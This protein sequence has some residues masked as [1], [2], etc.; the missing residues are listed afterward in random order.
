MTASS[1]IL[2][3]LF[4]DIEGSTLLWEQDPEAMR[5]ALT[6]HDAVLHEIIDEHGGRLF[7]HTGD[8][9]C[10]AFHSP[11]AA[12]RAAI[13]AQ[14]RSPLPVRIGLATGEAEPRADDYFGPVLNRTARVMSAGHGGQ[15]LLD[16]ATAGLLTSV[17]LVGLGP[18]RLRG[19]LDPVTLYQVRA[20]GLETD[21]P[22]LRT[23]DSTPGNLRSPTS[24]FVG[25][26]AELAGLAAAIGRHRL[27]TLTG[28]GGVGKT[29]LAREVARRSLQS[30]AD[31][32]FVIE[33]ASVSDP[34]AV[35]DAVAG[36]LGI[37]QQPGMDTLTS[38][39]AALEGRSRL[40][41]FDNCEHLL[42]A[43]ARMIEAILTRSAT[44]KI[45][46]TSRESLR[47][48]DEQ[49]WPVPP[50]DFETDA[51]ALFV[52]RAGAA[53]PA[54]ELRSCMNTVADI[55]RR[56]DG[57][58][59]A[60]ELAASRL[61][62]MTVTEVRE[63]L[64]DRFRLLVGTRRGIERH[65]TLRHAV[66]W[67]YDLLDVD[68][69]AL[70]ERTS[71]F[72]GGFELAAACA[73]AQT[74]D[75]FAVLD[76]LDSLVRKSLLV[77]ERGTE[78]TRFSMLETIRQF[79][80]EKLAEGGGADQARDTHARFFACRERDVLALWDGARQREAYTWFA[81]EFA[82]LR[83]AF[84]WAADLGDLDVA[85][86]VA[87]YAAFLGIRCEQHEPIAWVEEL[88]APATRAAHPRLA[89]LLATASQ[90]YFSGRIDDA[91]AYA[92]ATLA[93]ITDGRFAEVPVASEAWL[94]AIYL[95]AGQAETWLARCRC[96]AA[97]YSPPD[98]FAE[99]CLA[100]TLAMAD[101]D[102]E[103][104]AVSAHL[105]A[106][107][108]E[109]LNP[110][111]ASYALLSFGIVHRT[112]DPDAALAAHRR[113]L[114]IAHDSGNEQI[115]SYHTGN[116]AR[117]AVT[118]GDPSDAFDYLTLAI[119]RFHDSGSFSLLW[120]AFSVL[121]THFDRLGLYPAAA[122]VSAYA[123]TPFT[124]AAYPE[125]YETLAHIRQM[126]GDER[127]L[128][129]VEIG[130]KLTTAAMAGYALGQIDLHRAELGV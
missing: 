6:A 97:R 108:E 75:R 12:V 123:D 62:A 3:F 128:S 20:P 51:A 57:I 64:D 36:V 101:K 126:L 70:L 66:Q 93:A 76:L 38:V 121:A 114:A 55:C 83:A 40:L 58:P 61:T 11:H 129:E 54:V 21:F 39:A 113:G 8:G 35:P 124:R 91:V 105:V 84:R 73:V 81:V 104:L 98:V 52:A 109:T 7:K 79:A 46:A 74:S 96:I 111:V 115:E 31:G 48:A 1:G 90:C 107:A 85:C 5:S 16:A 15:I 22:P 26:E 78:R 49:L 112:A 30:F 17:E 37:S 119:R 68:E 60:I 34:E 130:R 63:A 94:G 4:T 92:D 23:V 103:A 47:N 125:Y 28:V 67:S 43:A 69:R 87:Y 14:K 72:A 88:I 110:H 53:A 27:V 106:A 9:V 33:L 80:E 99:A 82:N 77:A 10:A 117:M 13:E 29:R 50:L 65:Q 41:L 44:V 24:S 25:R 2:T 71:V 19:I 42:E 89:Q 122:R 102:A 116:L 120:N 18:R 59:L 56:L 127:F 118:Y 100:T 45:L 95:A 86:A 32:V